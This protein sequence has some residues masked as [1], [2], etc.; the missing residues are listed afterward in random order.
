MSPFRSLPRSEI[1]I[2]SESGNADQRTKAI[3]SGTTVIIDDVSMVISPGDEIRRTL[4]N[5]Q[6][7][8]F[9][10]DDPVF[11]EKTFSIPPHY[12]VKVSR[13][14]VFPPHKGGNYNVTISGDNSRVNIGST[15]YSVNIVVSDSIFDQ[16]SEKIASLPDQETRSQLTPLVDELKTKQGGPGFLDAY[17]RFIATVGDHMTVFAPLLPGLTAMIA[18]A[19]TA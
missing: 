5:G 8:A 9:R 10:V 12:Q 13:K 15:D 4:P 11:Y 7:E 19:G 18:G 17:Q 3:I 1:T 2:V 6:E 14:G 16:L